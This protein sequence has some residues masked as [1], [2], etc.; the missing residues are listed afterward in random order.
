MDTL[1][2][3]VERTNVNQSEQNFGHQLSVL[4]G[5]LES[6]KTPVFS[7][8]VDFKYTNYNKAHV[9]VM[10]LL[11]NANIEL[12]SNMLGYITVDEDRAKE[13]QNLTKALH[14]ECT[15]EEEFTDE[16]HLT[17]LCSEVTHNPIYD[18]DNKITGVM[19]IAKDTTTAK[20][21]EEKL[22]ESEKSYRRLFESAKDGILILDALTGQ[23]D[24]A[25][26]FIT[27]M[28][29][30]GYHELIGKE[31]WEIGTFKNI[32]P[33]K[34]AFVELQKNGYIRFENM[35]LETKHGRRINVEFISNVY[36]VDQAKV[37][38][39]NIRDITERIMAHEQLLVAKAKAEESD[40][41]K[42]AFLHNISH[43]I[44]TPMN[45]IVGFSGF[46][47][48]PDL[49][50]EKRK[51][52]TDIIIQSSDQLLAIIDDIICI[53]S[54]EAGLEKNQETEISINSICKLLYDQFSLKT[55]GKAVLLSM[56]TPLADNEATVITDSTKLTQI[57]NNLIGNALKFTR[58]GYVNFGYSLKGNF[59]EFFVEDSGIGIPLDM[60]GIVFNR[61]RQVEN[62]NEQLFGGSGIGLS[63]SKAYVEML[64]GK[65]WLTSELGK[66][67]VF[68]FTIPYKR[69]NL[70]KLAANQPQKGLGVDLEA[71]K[72]ILVAE[73]DGSN[74][75]LLNEFLSHSGVAIIRA[76]NGAEAVALCKANPQ[77][78]L[79][80]MDIKMPVMDGY[81]ATTRIKEFRPNLPIVALT[82]YST[83]VDK[84]R[85]LACGCADF[86]SKPI[87]KELL[88]AKINEY[89]R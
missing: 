79:V 86:I 82:A 71:V 43:E 31:L 28:L 20:R 54:I 55:L 64:G 16:A 21:G 38:Q 50:D 1:S 37:I 24:D 11:Y 58:Q 69:A 27:D 15:V 8:D 25:N 61:F 67:S 59:L 12:N 42:T 56:K 84:N 34:E 87:R 81:D 80:L 76:L 19:V 9:A 4:K 6:I 65:I 45:A 68:N 41:L 74:F 57:L 5:I 85:A 18:S 48:E 66:G 26:P 49:I 53:A 89:L 35:P 44:R 47:V 14:H 62:T 78:S 36:L 10:K 33:S 7:V 40:R 60:Q 30:Y 46:L 72:E 22:R 70:Q 32:V 2:S 23:I 63:I 52:F 3:N 39:C 77:I 51:L 75:I 13:K 73:D 88:L 17:S 29:G 83:E